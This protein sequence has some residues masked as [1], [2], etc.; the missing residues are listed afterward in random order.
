[1]IPEGRGDFGQGH[2]AE[3]LIERQRTGRQVAAA[4]SG[5]KRLLSR[6]RIGQGELRLRLP[7]LRQIPQVH[8]KVRQILRGEFHPFVLLLGDGFFHGRLMVPH[9][10]HEQNR[11]AQRLPV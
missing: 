10:L 1:V 11:I 7:V 8:G 3:A 9:L 2:V 4:A 6:S 5:L